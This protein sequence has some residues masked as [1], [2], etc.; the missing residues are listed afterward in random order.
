M[1]FIISLLE[2]LNHVVFVSQFVSESPPQ[3]S[4]EV[5]RSGERKRKEKSRNTI[6]I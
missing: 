2:F 4:L 5:R 6:T 3:S 1:H